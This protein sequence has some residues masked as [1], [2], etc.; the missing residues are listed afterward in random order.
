MKVIC[1][2]CLKLKEEYYPNSQ[3]CED[4]AIKMDKK[5]KELEE[6]E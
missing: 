1:N 2:A 4:C 3:I 5:I 6:K